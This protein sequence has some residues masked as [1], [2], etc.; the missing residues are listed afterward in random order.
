MDIRKVQ[1]IVGD[2][3][4]GTDGIKVEITEDLDSLKNSDK[5]L[6]VGSKKTIRY[7]YQTAKELMN[8][9]FS[10]IEEADEQ[11]LSL[12]DKYQIN[13]NQ[14]FPIYG[15]SKINSEIHNEKILKEYQINKIRSI[16]NNLSSFNKLNCSH[17]SIRD[18][19]DDESIKPSYKNDSIIYSVL[20]K[21]DISIDDLE[22]YLKEYS[23]S[24]STDYN[25][26]LVVYD[27]LKYGDE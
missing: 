12:I 5:V 20:I 4:K 6:A 19:L 16:K 21:K 14:Y 1:D 17:H 2:I 7:Q 22:K 11:R 24:K 15:F 18:I 26:L 9:Y 3:Y 23:D 27:Y 25:K 10:V 8:K 13:S